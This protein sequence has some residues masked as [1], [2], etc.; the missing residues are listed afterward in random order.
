MI[1][2]KE[3]RSDDSA[4]FR[5]AQCDRTARVISS[6]VFGRNIFPIS[7]CDHGAYIRIFTF[8]WIF[9][10]R[11]TRDRHEYFIQYCK[12]YTILFSDETGTISSCEAK[13]GREERTSLR[14]EEHTSE[15]QSR[16]HLI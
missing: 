11:L 1:R 12:P 5:M 16:G 9:V 8:P 15:L 7:W 13:K 10:Y 14:S 4:I 2:W 3:G 6:Y